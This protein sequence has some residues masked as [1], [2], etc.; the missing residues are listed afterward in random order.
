MD[1]QAFLRAAL[2]LQHDWGVDE[3]LDELAAD[4]FAA[5]QAGVTRA[6][7]G[8]AVTGHAGT[9]QAGADQA[10]ANQAGA[11]R[12]PAPPSLAGPAATGTTG[13]ADAATIA[14]GCADADA[15][16][17]AYA[18]FEACP[19]RATASRFVRP[20]GR[21]GTGLVWIGDPP[22]DDDDRTG[23]AG[24]GPDG[25]LFDRMLGSIGMTRADLLLVPV[26]AWRPPGGRMPTLQE[27][28]QCIPFV[29][30]LLELEGAHTLVLTGALAARCF[31][32]GSASRRG[33]TAT[34]RL[35]DG[36]SPLTALFFPSLPAL[37]DTPA[38]RQE[39]WAALRRLHR[40]LA[41]GLP[42]N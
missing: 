26:V 40:H 34:L 32:P 15:L 5:G 2:V 39:A 28:A 33:G 18:G 16:L 14:A 10:G 9:D 38:R 19:L 13:A 24:S 12:R 31:L 25:A 36:P 11:D 8:Q 7:A 30:R 4:R 20:A 21:P 17:A 23:E 37:R 35:A 41:A 29:R 6:M 1:T 42:K 22:G 27:C 3:A